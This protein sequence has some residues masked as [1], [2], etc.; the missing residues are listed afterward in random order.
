MPGLWAAEPNRLQDYLERIE[1]A[2]VEQISQAAALYGEDKNSVSD[3]L[4]IEGENAVITINGVLR[5]RPAS[6][7]ARYLGI[8]GASY[9]QIIQAVETL[10]KDDAVTTVT[11]KFDTPGGEVKGVDDAYQALARLAKRKTLIAQVRG[12]CCSAGY[13]LAAAA[14]R[15]VSTAPIH[16]IGSIGIVFAQV[17]WKKIDEKIGVKEI[18]ITSKNAPNKRPDITTEKGQSIVQG[19]IDAAERIFIRRI[20]QGRKVSEQTV[21]KTFGQGDMLVAQ[22]PDPDK[23]DAL[24]AGMIDEVETSMPLFN[25]SRDNQ[26][27]KQEIKTMPGLKEAM[28]ADP[29]VKQ[30]VDALS[31][32]Q[33]ENG[34]KQGIQ[35]GIETLQAKIKKTAP[36]LTGNSYPEAIKSLAC[37]VLNG[38]SEFS[39][40]E[41]AV[42][43]YDA[44]KESQSSQ[45][46]QKETDKTDDTPG[47]DQKPSPAADGTVESQEDYSA[48]IAEDKNRLGLK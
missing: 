4:S 37:K 43:V 20:A 7:L 15:I 30:E 34:K 13:Y 24:S 48:L 2:G 40:L 14:G 5:N 22:D 26:P 3:I 42:T 21:A 27:S 8:A 17:S 39:A 19:Q 6:A 11:M 31:A 10:I 29:T 12:M 36:Y 47:Q 44:Q 28:D 33:F 23:P 1:N 9:P 25:Q 35:A 32:K 45:N 18:V 16:F 41:G 46:A 38:E